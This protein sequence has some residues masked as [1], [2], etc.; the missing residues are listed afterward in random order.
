V[1]PALLHALR[2]AGWVDH[3]RLHSRAYPSNRHVIA[4]PEMSE[5]S[6]SDIRA[7]VEPGLRAVK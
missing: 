6:K 5:H 1:A 4:A 7:A 2:E 3:G